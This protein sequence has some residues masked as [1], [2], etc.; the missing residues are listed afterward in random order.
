MISTATFIMQL[1]SLKLIWNKFL[2][3]IKFDIQIQSFYKVM[4]FQ[5]VSFRFKPQIC[6][7]RPIILNTQWTKPILPLKKIPYDV[8]KIVKKLEVI[9]D[10]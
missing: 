8:I 1:L 9:Y 5:N 7:A 2:E 10:F 4:T 3:K 6:R